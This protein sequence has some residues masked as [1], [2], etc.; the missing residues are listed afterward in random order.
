M[1]MHTG[2]VQTP[3]ES[4]HRKLTLVEKSLAAPGIEPALAACRSDAYQL[5]Y[6]PTQRSGLAFYGKCR[7]LSWYI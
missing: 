4:L 2:G 1:R 7:I 5:S 3:K 6:F